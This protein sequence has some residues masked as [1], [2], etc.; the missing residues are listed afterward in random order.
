LNK[1][2]LTFAT[3][4]PGQPQANGFIEIE[5][6]FAIEIEVPCLFDFDGDFD[7]GQLTII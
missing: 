7:F 5:I 6:E 3:K 1:V 2:A 4:L